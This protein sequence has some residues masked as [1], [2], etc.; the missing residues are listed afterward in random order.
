LTTFVDT[1]AILLN[2][3][4]EEH[5]RAAA[6]YR[7]LLETGEPLFSTNYILVE[8]IALL[9]R[10]LGIAAVSTFQS[11][12]LPTLDVE[13]LTEESHQAAMAD[14]LAASRRRLSLVD[15]SSFLVMKRRGITRAFAVDPHFG[16][17][18]FQQIPE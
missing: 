10:R 6:T 16:E 1:S 2:A 4:D 15:C 5:S 18:G 11:D 14:L 3:A 13:W 7:N 8:T 9:Q 17:H 12:I